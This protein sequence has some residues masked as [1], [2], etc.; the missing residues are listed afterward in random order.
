M[1]MHLDVRLD[2]AADRARFMCPNCQRQLAVR[3]ARGGW[4]VR[5]TQAVRGHL[6]TEHHLF[7]RKKSITIS[8]Q[9]V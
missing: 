5:V 7:A 8:E 2:R 4:R 3:I 1:N 9:E 6:G